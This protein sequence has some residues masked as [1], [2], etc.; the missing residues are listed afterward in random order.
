MICKNMACHKL[1]SALLTWAADCATL[2]FT[3][4]PKCIL[5]KNTILSFINKSRDP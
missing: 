4:K 3:D 5:A 2:M 1:R